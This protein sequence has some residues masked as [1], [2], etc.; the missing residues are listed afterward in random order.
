MKVLILA[1][2]SSGLYNFR[3]ELILK[4][5]Q[6]GFEVSFTVPQSIGDEKVQ[7]LREA[8]ARYI[9]AP[10]NRRG[11]NPLEDLKLIRH[12]KGI[13][14]NVNP[15]VILTYTI[16]PNVYGSYVANKLGVPVIM[17]V[18]GIG[19]SLASGKLRVLVKQMY[20]YA[21]SRAYC[22]F[23]QN[24]GNLNFFLSNRLVSEYRTRLIPGSG[25]NLDKFRPTGKANKDDGVIRFLY[26]GRIMKEKGIEEYLEVADML[27]KEYSDIEF[28]ILGSFEE[29]QY[30]SVLEKN[31]NSRI[32][33]LGQSNDVRN[34][35]REVDCI[36]NPSYHE[37]MSNVLLEGAAMGKPLIASNIPGCREIIDDGG[38]GYLFDVKSA[39]S[40]KEKIEQFIRLSS[41]RREQ[42]GRHS[43]AKVEREFDRN[44]VINEYMKVINEIVDR[45]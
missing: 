15:A 26:I 3:F 8:G 33:Y 41:E 25:V 38:N 39:V 36:V 11:T 32:K 28:Q 40:L 7:S 1:N 44:I 35:I 16:K 17:N 31:T 24:Q 43:R 20:K 22:V 19:S 30:R 2:K 29:E 27:T 21:C 12:Y 5:I 14:K 13:I 34:E 9:H 4:L 45:K 37:G 42:M 6:E 18:T 23:F 10:M